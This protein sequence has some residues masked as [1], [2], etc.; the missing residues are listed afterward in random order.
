MHS[1]DTDLIRTLR[2]AL[3]ADRIFVGSDIGHRYH[4]DWSQKNPREPRALLKP[5]STEEVA[6]CLAQCSRAGQPIVVQG[7]LT[8]L[9]GGATPRP[10]EVSL[11]LERLSGIENLDPHDCTVDVRAGTSLQVVQERAASR[12]L[13]F[14]L[15]LGA[16][17][18][19]TIGGNIATN[20]GGNRV[21]RY[22]MMR[23]L[24]LGLE[25][26]LAD[27]TIL[28]SLNSM[29]KN[30][31]GYDLKQLFIGSEGT[32]GIV[33]R[34]VLR[35]HAAPIDRATA[36]VAAPSFAAV[37]DALREARRELGPLLSAFEVMW[38]DYF[39]LASSR[40]SKGRQPFDAAHPF[41]FLIEVEIFDPGA[42][43]ERLERLLHRLAGDG[44]ASDAVIA[45]SLDESARLWAIR[46]SAGELLQHMAPAVAYDISLP[47]ERMED[48][49]NT[50]TQ[51]ACA[52]L[53][54]H[55]FYF[56]GHLGDGN[57]HILA[58]LKDADDAGRVD[59]VI[60]GELQNFGSISAEHGIGVRKAE[61]LG[62]SRCPEE[63]ALMKALKRML[64]PQSI[65]NPGRIF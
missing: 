6:E 26:V 12:N 36:L 44:I 16:R 31:T 9:V 56:F 5:R 24:V 46:E 21:L 7:G 30:N 13:Q 23:G 57:L 55:P 28:S 3:G 60:Y 4:C 65:L 42:D 2:S 29:L 51:Q 61:H 35:V 63:I 47:I 1:Q 59:E 54:S 37:K 11:S 34:A 17:G 52:L 32:L 41:Y 20:A 39:L 43:C 49:V 38:A 8:G 64:D 18:T 48:Y 62:K 40:V 53:G 27:G 50:V 14:S 45:R 22:G 19:C 33:T 58:A 25:V 10:G 15:D